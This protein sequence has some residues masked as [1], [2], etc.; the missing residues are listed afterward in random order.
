VHETPPT[1]RQRSI[2]RWISGLVIVDLLFLGAALYF[3]QVFGETPVVLIGEVVA[4]LLF[5]WFWTVQTFQR[6][7]DANPPSILPARR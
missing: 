6:W 7:Y 5:A 1:P 3:R 2:Y 4:L